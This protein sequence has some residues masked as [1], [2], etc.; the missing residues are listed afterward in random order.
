MKSFKK[1]VL[2]KNLKFIFLDKFPDGGDGFE[3][4]PDERKKI[5][6]KYLEYASQKSILM[7]DREKEFIESLIQ[8][9]DMTESFS[10]HRAVPDRVVVDFLC[11]EPLLIILNQIIHKSREICLEA[12]ENHFID[13]FKVI[14]AYHKGLID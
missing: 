7:T 13:V 1:V 12:P 4:E 11:E 8:G 6:F 2:I 14:V 10:P 3:G 5:A 9:A